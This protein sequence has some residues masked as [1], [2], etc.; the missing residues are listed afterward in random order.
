VRPSKF[1]PAASRNCVTVILVRLSCPPRTSVSGEPQPCWSLGLYLRRDG[2]TLADVLPVVPLY[3]A[4][5]CEMQ[6]MIAFWQP[7]AVQLNR[8]G[9][10]GS[11]LASRSTSKWACEYC[12][13]R[14]RERSVSTR[15]RIRAFCGSLCSRRRSRASGQ[16][17]YW[18][19]P[20][21]KGLRTVFSCP[22]MSYVD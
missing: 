5:A 20:A 13:P 8:N 19:Y 12:L 7:L 18:L 10:G 6:D 3:E 16:P 17:R 14:I 21:R 1:S 22:T 15:P 11:R 4:C 2:R 9:R